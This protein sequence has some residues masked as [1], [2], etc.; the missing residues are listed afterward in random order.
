MSN[1]LGALSG[2]LSDCKYCIS[3]LETDAWLAGVLTTGELFLWN[4]DQDCLKTIQATEKPK[5][6]IKAAAGENVFKLV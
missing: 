6:M 3:F 2:A 1:N 5:E 4:K